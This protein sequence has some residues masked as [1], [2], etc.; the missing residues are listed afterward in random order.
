MTD[1]GQCDNCGHKMHCQAVFERLSRT[2][3][4]NV[5]LKVTVAFVLPIL[6]FIV[7]LV[8]FNHLVKGVFDSEA[9]ETVFGFFAAA[10]ATAICVLVTAGINKYR[11]RRY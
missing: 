5:A 2:E 6:V 11:T 4:P 10:G 7:S 3:G 1:Q 9:Y 8:V